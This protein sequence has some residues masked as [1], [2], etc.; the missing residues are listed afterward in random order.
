MFGFFRPN[1]TEDERRQNPDNINEIVTTNAPTFTGKIDK[2]L[3]FFGHQYRFQESL[4][5]KNEYPWCKH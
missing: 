4:I 3:L 1:I 2:T 5:K